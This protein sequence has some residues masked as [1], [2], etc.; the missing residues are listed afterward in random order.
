MSGIDVDGFLRLHGE[1]VAE[2]ADLVVPAE[3]WTEDVW[4]SASAAG[5]FDFL[6]GTLHER[7]DW[8]ER[9]QRLIESPHPES[10]PDWEWFAQLISGGYYADAGNG[11]NRGELS[12]QMIGWRPGPNRTA[13]ASGAFLPGP[14]DWPA[15]AFGARRPDGIITPDELRPR[16]DVIVVGSGAGGGVAAALLAESGRSV[17]VVEAGDWPSGHELAKDHLRNPRSDWGVSVLSGPDD[18][19]HPRVLAAADGEHLLRP[20]DWGWG[21][22]AFTAGG[23]TRVYG[24]Q[25]WRFAPQDFRMASTYGVP[26][27]SALA[28]WPIGYDDLEP[29]YRQAEWELGVSGPGT[30]A[31]L[32]GIRSAPYPMPPL[33]G[34]AV[35]AVLGA[36]A[37]RLGWQPTS[38]PLLVNSL[39]YGGRAAC[40]QCAMCVGFDCPVG[41]K[42]GSHNTTLARALGRAFDSGGAGGNASLLLTTTVQR[43]LTDASGR[44]T[45]VRLVGTGAVGTG[46]VGTGAEAGLWHADVEAAEIVL[47]AGAVES[48]RLLLNSPTEREPN[49]IG[50][51][52]DQVGRH[53][54]GHVYT[55]VT[56]LFDRDVVD[57]LGPG[58]SI[59][60][61]RF[62]HGN[63]GIVGGGMLASEFVP[64]PANTYRYLVSAGLIPAYGADAKRGMHDD[65]SR[66]M[67]VMGPIQEVTS[68]DSRVT[69]AHGIVD[70]LGI[71][72]ARLSGGLH[73]ADFAARDF[74]GDRAIEWLE[75]S[76]AARIVPLS[77]SRAQWGP[78]SGQ[79]QAGTCRMGDDPARSVV[80]PE[81]RVWGHDNVRIADASV[82]VTNGGVNPVL[83]V[84]ANAYRAIGLMTR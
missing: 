31:P 3:A 15:D 57:L 24:A 6:A 73:E 18:E 33:P 13:T 28:D 52:T 79:H 20:S 49:G 25:A 58:P 7:T 44:V 47:S 23:G 68:A 75:A 8:L 35:E 80:D 42:A 16:Y 48:A 62:R 38:V 66:M 64:L 37:R 51:S 14:A 40:L 82:H 39:A 70:R 43:L 34:G 26:E 2:L 17:L 67:R 36:G 41:A 12:W 53:L 19:G 81:G 72:V 32:D 83:T 45:G 63:P 27:G 76:G 4:P 30:P 21:N 60:I 46:A 78:S 84:L 10:A 55:G 29:Y 65:A 71:P 74:L 61:T 9:L 69:L 22:N 54:Q 50:N 5:A 1:R 77:R 11:G 56:A 59:A